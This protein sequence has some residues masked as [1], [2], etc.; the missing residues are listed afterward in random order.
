LASLPR[1]LNW[2]RRG[3]PKPAADDR[4]Y[5]ASPPVTLLERVPDAL[6][7]LDRDWRFSY[8]N[9]A[10]ERLLGSPREELLG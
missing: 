3:N 2:K 5:R 9:A 8:L 7:S 4:E 10:A 6:F 1:S